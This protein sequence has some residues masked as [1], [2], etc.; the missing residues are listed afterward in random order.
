M[1]EV[2]RG[3]VLGPGLAVLLVGADE[4]TLSFL[5]HVELAAEVDDVQH[6]GAG[7]RDLGHLVGDDVLVLHRREGMDHAGHQ[8]D[9]ARP[10]P[11]RVHHV[12]RVQRALLRHHVP[13]AVG[14]LGEVHHR[15]LAVDLRPALACRAG[16]GVGHARRVDVSLVRVVEHPDIVLR[17]QDRQPA[18]RLAQIDELGVQAKV[19]ATAAG[20]VQVVEPILGVGEHEAAGEVDAAGLP[21]DLLDL[22]VDLQRVVLELGDVGVGVER[23]HAARRMPG[24]AGGEL[25]AFEQDDILP[26][27]LDEVVQDAATDDAS[28]DDSHSDM[29][30]HASGLRWSEAGGRRGAHVTV[31]AR[32]RGMQQWSKALRAHSR[33][34]RSPTR[35]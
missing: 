33:S 34:S 32:L 23:V 4:D 20:G 12:L 13:G 24:G 18:D 30:F 14:A 6:L 8:P 17:L 26:P 7:A 31:P 22:L 11:G 3:H 27:V 10:Q 29:R 2:P 25:G 9:L 5:A 21:G 28:A 16:I 1:A 19:A 15:S 35:S